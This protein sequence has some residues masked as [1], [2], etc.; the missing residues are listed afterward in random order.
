MLKLFFIYINRD[1]DEEIYMDKA[2][3]F[4]EPD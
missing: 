2:E 3:G 4:I 1:L